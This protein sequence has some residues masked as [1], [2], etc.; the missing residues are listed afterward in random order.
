VDE[1]RARHGD[2][3]IQH[4]IEVLDAGGGELPRDFRQRWDEQAERREEL[5][6]QVVDGIIDHVVHHF[7]AHVLNLIDGFL[8][9]F[10]SVLLTLR[11]DCLR[12]LCRRRR[13]LKRGSRSVR[14]LP[15]KRLF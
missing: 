7:L 13:H 10:S 9:Q 14:N 11:V 1:C 6:H 3:L 12:Q 4:F 2:N 15:R 8:A 5:V